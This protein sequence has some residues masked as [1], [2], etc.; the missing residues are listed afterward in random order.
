M[1]AARAATEQESSDKPNPQ[2]VAHSERLDLIYVR[3]TD[4]LIEELTRMLPMDLE[5]FFEFFQ[6]NFS[7]EK[8]SFT[9]SLA[10]FIAIYIQFIEAE[11]AKRKHGAHYQKKPFLR[12]SDSLTEDFFRKYIFGESYLEGQD[13]IVEKLEQKNFQLP[14]KMSVQGTDDK[15]AQG[16]NFFLNDDFVRKFWI[17]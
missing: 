14:K 16:I 9:L 1:A 6:W 4:K 13:L 17:G 5:A 11:Y 3:D 8:S 15:N 2:T 7:L 12:A 10:Q